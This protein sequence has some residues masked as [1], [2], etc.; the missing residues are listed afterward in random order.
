MPDCT[1]LLR[2]FQDISRN[3]QEAGQPADYVFGTVVSEDPLKI[4][5][6]QKMVLSRAQLA[7]CRSVTDYE[8]E[9]AIDAAHGW[10]T[11]DAAGG[12]G[13]SSYEAHGHAITAERKKLRVLNALRKGEKV[14][15][16]K[17]KGG[18]QYLVLDRVVGA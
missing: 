7:L 12:S 15:M 4:Q 2:A 8:A 13:D 3:T 6:E 14:V 10:R 9:V 16:V 11:E 17:K 1:P 18:Q 5:V